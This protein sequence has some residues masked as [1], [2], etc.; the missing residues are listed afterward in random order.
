M[1]QSS[2]KRLRFAR[3]SCSELVPVFAMPQWIYKRDIQSLRLAA[4]R[5]L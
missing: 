5:S 2:K 3:N 1:L 4:G